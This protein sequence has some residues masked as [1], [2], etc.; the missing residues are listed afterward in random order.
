MGLSSVISLFSYLQPTVYTNVAY[1]ANSS[2]INDLALVPQ[3]HRG[4]TQGAKALRNPRFKTV[5]GVTEPER[6]RLSL[7]EVSHGVEVGG[8]TF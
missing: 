7:R 4:C 3:G 6:D 2:K 8:T 5:D 1:E